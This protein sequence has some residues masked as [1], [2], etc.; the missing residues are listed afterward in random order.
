[1]FSAT[2]VLRIGDYV[3]FKNQKSESFLS[4]EGILL[5]DLIVEEH[6]TVFDDCLFAIHLQRQYS[7]SRELEVFLK[8]DETEKKSDASAAKYLHALKR[9]ADNENKLNDIYLKKKTGDGVLFGDII[10]VLSL[11]SVETIE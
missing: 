11:L 4:A 5:E 6:V 10:Q 7:A 1:M 3:T 9:G 8:A 2:G